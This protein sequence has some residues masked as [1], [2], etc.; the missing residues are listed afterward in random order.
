MNPVTPMMQQYLDIKKQYADCILFFRLGDFYEMFYKDAEIA[1]K[2]LEIAL[3]GRDCGQEE[4]A[5]MCGIPYHAADQ[6]IARLISKGHKV[7]VCEQ[8]EDPAEAK[9]IVKRNVIK[10]ITPGT[11]TDVAMLDEK[12]NNYIASIFANNEYYGLAAAD[13]STGEFL[14]TSLDYGRTY[15]KLINELSKYMP[16]EIVLPPEIYN[17]E[18]ANQLKNKL[19]SYITEFDGFETDPD[20]AVAS[21]GAAFGDKGAS[22]AAALSGHAACAAAGL[23]GYIIRTQ[24]T[25]F[26]HMNTIRTYRTDD[27]MGLDHIARHNLELTET[28]REKK[29]KGSLLGVIDRTVT[30]MG[31]RLVRK[32][33]EMPLTDIAGIKDRLD[34]VAEFKEKFMLRMELREILR[35]VYDLERLA[36]RISLGS[37]GCRDLIALKISLGQLPYINNL[38]PGCS[39]GLIEK[40]AG[41]FDDLDDIFKMI[42]ISINNDPPLTLKEGGLIKPG[43]NAELDLLK[44]AGKEGKDW[45][46]ALENEEREKTG[47]RNLKV[48]YNRVFGYYI[49]VT[50]S[51]LDLVPAYFLRKQ[52]LANCERYITEDL[53]KIEDTILGADEKAKELEYAIFIEIRNGIAARVVRIKNTAA[54]VSEIDALAA[55]AEVADRENYCMPEVDGN[56][57]IDIRDG[58]HPVVEKMIDFGTFVPNDT[59]LDT[60][61]NRFSIITGPN[62]AGKSTYMRQVAL[63][64][65]LAQMGSF[66]PASKARIGIADRI[67]TRVGASDDL[68]AGQSTFMVEMSEVAGIINSATPKSLLIL[69][70]IGRGTSTFDG[71]SIAWAVTEFISN[72]AKIGCRALFA[73]HYHELTEL[74]GKLP[75]VKNYCIT[76]EEKDDNII[77]LRKIIRGGA[78]ESYGIQVAKLAGIPDPVTDRAKEILKVLEDAD[79]SKRASRIRKG[80]KPAEGQMDIYTFMNTVNSGSEVLD[81][82]KNIDIRNTTPVDALNVLYKLQQK[83][84]KGI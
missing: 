12:R 1:S 6:Y 27:Y 48:G 36:G 73:T 44:N 42:E 75:G 74:E 5:P 9:G 53:K 7:A 18:E 38:L 16:S 22:E 21:I 60:D 64:V 39:S 13:I 35:K 24:K 52:T 65:I 84:R 41:A 80:T 54:L 78:D 29:K 25:S 72:K 34:A 77:F 17:T 43:Y 46:A 8:L 58:R 63:I 45:I 14:L 10:I 30:P 31:G 37:A 61:L 62:M 32:W 51:H 11:V 2:D 71:L 81:E 50:K 20:K 68:S 56:D 19:G 59:I 15:E 57:L 26:E 66:V 4:R 82:L 33:L 23:L 28:I 79:I 67:F 55:L 3:T 70:E 40:I 47:I 69:D 49:E 76:V 83:A